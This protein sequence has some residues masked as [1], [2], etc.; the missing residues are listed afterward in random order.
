VP[1]E[2]I[3]ASCNLFTAVNLCKN[4]ICCLKMIHLHTEPLHFE[5]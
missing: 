3:I 5:Q 2:L 4:T 1:E